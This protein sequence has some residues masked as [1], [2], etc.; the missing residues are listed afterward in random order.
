MAEKFDLDALDMRDNVL[1][2][3]VF[4][5]YPDEC[6]RALE[7]I[8]G[9]GISEVVEIRREAAVDP[10]VMSRGVRLDVRVRDRGGRVFDVEVQRASEVARA[11]TAGWLL[12]RARYYQGSCDVD[13]LARG[14]RVSDLPEL[15]IVFICDFD[16]LGAGQRRYTVVRSC[17]QG[18][19]PADNG[20]HEEYLCCS[21]GEGE[22]P[23]ELDALLRFIGGDGNAETELTR[24]LGAAVRDVKADEVWRAERMTLQEMLDDERELGR[25]EG[26]EEG[27]Q[28]GRQEGVDRMGRLAAALKE[29]GRGDEFFEALGNPPKL[30]ELFAEFGIE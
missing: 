17:A 3:T 26:R 8:L 24:D 25:E 14:T 5:R 29:N 6:R 1:F 23:G 18:G 7:T 15:F 30:A 19:L 21:E 9:L 20:V 2:G 11:D 4:E 16:P 27:R 10:G 12:R 13:T 28:E 22:V